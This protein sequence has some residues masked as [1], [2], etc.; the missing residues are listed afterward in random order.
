MAPRGFSP[1]YEVPFIQGLPMAEIKDLKKEST[2]KIKQNLRYKRDKDREKVRGIFR[3][4]EVPGG[5]MSFMYKAYKEDPL[6]KFD[7]IDGG[8]YTIPLGVARHL[9]NNCWYPVHDYTVDEQGKPSMKIGRKVHRC[10][11]QSLEFI[12]I[13][14]MQPVADILTAEELNNGSTSS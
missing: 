8:V 14:D 5:S 7:F 2:S 4:N 1:I 12:D 6:E 10:S 11:F 9:N 13:D 3:F